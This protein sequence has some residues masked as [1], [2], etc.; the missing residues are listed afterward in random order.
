[1]DRLLLSLVSL[2]FSLLLLMLESRSHKVAT[3]RFRCMLPFATVFALKIK[4]SNSRVLLSSLLSS[5]GRFVYFLRRLY[6]W[7]TFLLYGNLLSRKKIPT[8]DYFT[9]VALSLLFYL[10]IF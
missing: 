6:M 1:M 5:I 2:C 3:C 7:H 8:S 10:V 4:S 9:S